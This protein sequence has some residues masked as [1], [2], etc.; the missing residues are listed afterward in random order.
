MNCLTSVFAAVSRRPVV[1]SAPCVVVPVV[2]QRRFAARKGTRE[3][4]RKLHKKRVIEKTE[5]IP[6][7]ERRAQQYVSTVT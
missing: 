2:D 7:S 5:W 6:P 3:K 1:L 4:R